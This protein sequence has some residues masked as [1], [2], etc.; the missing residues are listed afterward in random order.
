MSINSTISQIWL[1]KQV[2]DQDKILAI[3]NPSKLF[4]ATTSQSIACQTIQGVKV[5]LRNN[6]V[7]EL[8]VMV[9]QLW[10]VRLVIFVLGYLIPPL[11]M[12]K[13]QITVKGTGCTWGRGCL[14]NYVYS[15][16]NPSGLDIGRQAN[17][18]FDEAGTFP[19]WFKSK[20]DTKLIIKV[21]LKACY[22]LSTD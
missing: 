17:I 9:V 7:R 1:T 3:K 12:E 4:I 11:P 2:Q 14:W 22:C 13:I 5:Y 6:V 19:S 20:G 15:Y 18:F 21:S 16:P 10:C 8:A